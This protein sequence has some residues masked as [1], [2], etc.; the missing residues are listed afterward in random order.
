MGE[1]SSI[2]KTLT[3]NI[4]EL[5]I[6]LKY[7]KDTNYMMLRL[8][9]TEYQSLAVRYFKS[10]SQ[11]DLKFKYFLELEFSILEFKVTHKKLQSQI[12]W[13]SLS[14]FYKFLVLFYFQLKC[15]FLEE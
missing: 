2:T 9:H 1:V 14:T 7:L 4:I 15:I 3:K 6:S 12:L 8:F 10:M 13:G 11:N 5:L